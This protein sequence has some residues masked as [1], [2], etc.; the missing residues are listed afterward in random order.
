M[1]WGRC[2]RKELRVESG[3]ATLSFSKGRDNKSGTFSG[4]IRKYETEVEMDLFVS[5]LSSF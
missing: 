1:G 4:Y 5:P 3:E 2:N